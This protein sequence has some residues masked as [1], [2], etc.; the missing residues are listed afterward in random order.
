MT[1]FTNL[2]FYGKQ[3]DMPSCLISI[4]FAH[5]LLLKGYMGYLAHVY[6]TRVSEVRLKDV[7]VVRNF[8]DVFPSELL[9]LL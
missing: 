3:K 9:S 6:D 7:V 2:A 4:F 5:C 1:R 8:F